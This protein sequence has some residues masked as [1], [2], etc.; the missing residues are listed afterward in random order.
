[1]YGRFGVRGKIHEIHGTTKDLG[2]AKVPLLDENTM[3]S[4]SDIREPRFQDFLHD[5]V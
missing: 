1:M 2:V 3:L 4:A 5:V